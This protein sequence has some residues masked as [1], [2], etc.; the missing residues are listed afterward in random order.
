MRRVV[1]GF[2]GGLA[3]AVLVLALSPRAQF[4]AG[5]AMVNA[6][7]RM[8]D[9]LHDYDF[10]H[11]NATPEQVWVEFVKQNELASKVRETFPRTTFH[12]VVAMLVCMDARIDTNELAG[13]TRR[14]YYIVRTA[15]SAMSL[16]EEE[17]LEL[18][19]ANGVKLIVITRHT[20]CAAEKAMLKPELRA[21]YPALMEALTERDR[22]TRDF[23]ERPVIA[24]RIKEGKLLV[25]VL[26]IDTK[27]EHLG[28]H[29][30]TAPPGP[31]A[32]VGH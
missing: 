17:M 24:Q 26:E 27:T 4:L 32:E 13:D 5:G 16:K 2:A 3:V 14:N 28:E 22:R 19:V 6:A 20:D 21:Q 15:G 12:P 11:P 8:Q 1:A 23:L 29:H 18:A 9:H 30:A 10:E 25:K 31:D 7:Y